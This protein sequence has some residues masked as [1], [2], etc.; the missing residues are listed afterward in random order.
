[1]CAHKDVLNKLID[2][3][4]KELSSGKHISYPTLPERLQTVK[5]NSSLKFKQNFFE[6][7]RMNFIRSKVSFYDK[8]VL[9]IGCNAG[10]FLFGAIDDHAK[11]VTGYEGASYCH[12]FV[13]SAINLLG[14]GDKFEF[15]ARYYD[16][17][18]E[19][20]YKYDI[21][22]LLN[23][24][25]HIGDDYDEKSLKFQDV[26]SKILNQLN[27]LSK[28]TSVLIYQMGFNWHG[29]IETPLFESGTKREM[30]DFIKKGTKDY[31]DVHAIGIPEKFGAHI[32]YTDM[33]NKNIYRDDSL[34]E[35]LNRPLFILRSKEN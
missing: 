7:E 30:I 5:N 34:G 17:L 22:I 1:M 29:N 9:D 18:E 15:F 25:H 23:V 27:R 12:E 19:F 8:T 3:L 33:S 10:Y 2:I 11:R 14:D 28:S 13:K 4:E 21:T 26:K 32:S 16:F 20:P 31:W 35:F 6:R 24:M